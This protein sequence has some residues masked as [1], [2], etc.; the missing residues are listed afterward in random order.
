MCLKVPYFW[1]FTIATIGI[2]HI[3]SSTWKWVAALM[4]MQNCGCA[5]VF[6][7]WMNTAEKSYAALGIP[8]RHH[9][10]IPDKNVTIDDVAGKSL[11]GC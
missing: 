1:W 10:Q 9:N 11:E 4:S 8:K 3:A 2:K 7:Y 5:F 6:G